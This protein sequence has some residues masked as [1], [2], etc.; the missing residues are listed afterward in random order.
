MP[1]PTTATFLRVEWFSISGNFT[2]KNTMIGKRSSQAE[3]LEVHGIEKSREVLQGPRF[4][5]CSP[6]VAGL[7]I[8]E[9][10]PTSLSA[11]S[12]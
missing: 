5:S 12:V 3:D 1:V 11:A 7:E 6:L 9:S 4:C 2:I 10:G 8:V